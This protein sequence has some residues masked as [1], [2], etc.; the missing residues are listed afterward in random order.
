M[1]GKD[2]NIFAPKDNAARAEIAAVL[3]RFIEN[4]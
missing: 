2:N 3:Q 4:N 1:Q